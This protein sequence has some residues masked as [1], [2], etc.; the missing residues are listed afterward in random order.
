MI[1]DVHFILIMIIMHADS[2]KLYFLIFIL[3]CRL[4]V[5]L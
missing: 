2:S 1:Y 5:M 4:T 3:S